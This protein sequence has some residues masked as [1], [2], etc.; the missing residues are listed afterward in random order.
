MVEE[1]EE[2]IWGV[3]RQKNEC[4][5]QGED[6]QDIMVRPALAYWAGTY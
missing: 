4:E 5:Y 2:S 1:R 6:V 3:V